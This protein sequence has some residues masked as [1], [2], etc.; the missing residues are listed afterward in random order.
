MENPQELATRRLRYRP[1]KRVPEVEINQEKRGYIQGL[2]I[3][4]DLLGQRLSLL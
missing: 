4:L 3:S 1:G 2:L